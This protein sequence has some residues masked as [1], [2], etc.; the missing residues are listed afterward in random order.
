MT[1][2]PAAGESELPSTAFIEPHGDNR[3]AVEALARRAVKLVLDWATT[4]TQRPPLPDLVDELDLDA[5]LEHPASEDLLFDRLERLLEGSANLAHPGYTGHMDTAPTTIS[6]LGDLVAAAVNNNM[7]FAEMSPTLSALEHRLL[8]R[9]ARRFG[10]G[11]GAGGVLTAGGTLANLQALAVARNRALDCLREGLASRERGV[12]LA[13]EDAHASI[14]KAAMLLGLGTAGVVPVDVDTGGRMDPDALEERIRRSRRAGRR[15]F[16]VVGT[17]GT[18]VS[19]AIDPLDRIAGICQ[20]HDLWFHV[21][22]AYGGALIFSDRLRRRLAGIELAD[23]LTFNPH[24]W[25]F[26][27]RT[28]S[29]V[30]FRDAELLE[31]HFRVAAPY[32]SDPGAPPDG[33]GEMGGRATADR[34]ELG[35]I[36]VQGT[37]HAD[38]LKLW[39]TLQHLGPDGIARLVEVGC[40]LATRLAAGLRRRPFLELS[41]DRSEPDTGVVCFRGTPGWIDQWEWDVWNAGLQRHLASHCGVF[42]SLPSHRGGRWL[43]AVLLN[44]HLDEAF[45][46]SLLERIDGYAEADRRSVEEIPEEPG[47]DGLPGRAR[48]C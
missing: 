47:G 9:L 36:G 25:L 21:D 46:E 33:Q 28:C 8:G 1:A 26:V 24:K 13:S 30:L 11:A 23:S 22:A 32:S 20:A 43:R 40:E 35:E 3:A 10:L 14:D 45:L 17:A 2:D 15:P 7:L 19:G 18:T 42:L 48:E 29:M 34:P 31:R 12:I 4:A 16:C 5:L 44:P 41:G 27:A 37:R 6:V 38:V 39:L